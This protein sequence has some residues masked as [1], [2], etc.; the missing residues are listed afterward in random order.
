VFFKFLRYENFSRDLAAV[1]YGDDAAN[2]ITRNTFLTAQNRIV[3]SLQMLL[4]RSNTLWNNA[5][6]WYQKKVALEK[7]Q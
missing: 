4:A 2:D 7:P 5:A 3:V 6:T 1:H